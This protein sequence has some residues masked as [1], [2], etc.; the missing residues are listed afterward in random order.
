ME[1]MLERCCG[2]DV[3]K[4]SITACVMIGHGK[5]QFK[6]IQTFLT[7]TS[8]IRALGEWLRS[9]QIER[10]AMESTGIYW[11]PI[12]NIL[13]EGFDLYLVNAQHVKQVPGRKTD[14]KDSEWLC[15][16]LKCGLLR[17]S[18]IPPK[19]IMRLRELTRYRQKL[20]RQLCSE[21]NRLI[22][23]LENSNI[24]LSSVFSDVFGKTCWEIISK[25]VD[26][27][28]DLEKLTCCI[29]KRVRASRNDI[30]KALEGSLEPED[31]EMLSMMMAHIHYLQKT[32]ADVEMMID[33]HLEPFKAEVELLVTIPGVQKAGAAVII[34]EIGVNMDQFNDDSQ[35]VAW[36]GMCP[37]NNESAGK[38]RSSRIRKGNTHLKTV[39]V[40]LAWAASRTKNTYLNSKFR[41]LSRHKGNKKAIVAIGRKLLV[42]CYHMLKKKISFL[43]L[44][45][46]FLDSLESGRKL[47][48]HLKRLEEMGYEVELKEKH[49]EE[50]KQMAV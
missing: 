16:L 13:E 38:I 37:G 8:D 5:Q 15:K 45:P 42:I 41:A 39:L 21:K 36:A 47:K 18:F 33:R 4:E 23:A 6:E 40:Q 22:K 20:V 34:S 26:G 35:L 43:E 50:S 44:G 12:F 1:E 46:L 28:T 27:E 30:K 14:V 7:F 3:H 19:D 9:H 24:K 2:L 11:K 25:I 48:Y 49:K 31:I 32:I 10:V 29:N 17:K